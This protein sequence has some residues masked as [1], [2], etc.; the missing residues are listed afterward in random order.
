MTKA[1]FGAFVFMPYVRLFLTSHE[2]RLCFALIQALSNCVVC[3]A[4]S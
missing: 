2:H 4:Y 3:Y 1:P